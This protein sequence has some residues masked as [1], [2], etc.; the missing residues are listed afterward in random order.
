VA[1]DRASRAMSDRMTQ[2]AGSSREASAS[3]AELVESSRSVGD[4]VG[5]IREVTDE[6]VAR[7]ER[8]RTHFAET[9]AGIDEIRRATAAA[10]AIIRALDAR[11]REIGGI[12]DVI[13]DVGDQTSLLALNAAII[14]AQ[15][16]EHGR[17]FSV[18]AEEIRDLA[19]RVL[20]GTKEIAGL[21]RSVQAESERAIGAIEA[22]TQSV[23]SGVALASEVGRT[24]DEITRASRTTG[25]RIVSVASAIETQSR[26]LD[27]V[28]DATNLLGGAVGAIESADVERARNHVL[29]S[30]S[31]IALR[32]ALAG[33][34]NVVRGHGA[35]LARLGGELGFAL[36]SA[37]G[38]VVALEG[39][40]LVGRG[41]VEAIASGDRVMRPGAAPRGELVAAVESIR[42]QLDALRPRTAR[43]DSNPVHSSETARAKGE[44]A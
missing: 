21:I 12:L 11:T 27:R 37:R 3:L 41:L 22:G 4:S 7:A 8:G 42:S 28:V 38:L 5:S 33:Q 2:V 15:A 25:T 43:T 16:G 30:E 14:A 20:V 23:E 1:I 24:L 39:Q 29:A 10:E 18:V 32:D 17:S 19:D 35:G 44:R 13:D 40:A 34:Q 9:V 26:V 36:D 31:M 6:L